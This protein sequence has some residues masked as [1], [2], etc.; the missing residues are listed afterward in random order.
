MQ[1]CFAYI[2]VL[3]IREFEV[4]ISIGVVFTRVGALDLIVCQSITMLYFSE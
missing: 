2:F 4:E 1:L 3:G